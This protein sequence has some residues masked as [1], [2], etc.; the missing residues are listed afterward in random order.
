MLIVT[1]VS[2]LY[3]QNEGGNVR[4]GGAIVQASDRRLKRDIENI[5]YGLNEIVQ[6][7][8]TE[9]YWKGREQEFKS[10]GLIAQEVDEV[11]KNVVNYSE[12]EDEYGVNYMEL[13]PVLIKAI[14]EQQVII[15]T[16]QKRNKV[17]IKI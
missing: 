15:E 5:T 4:I 6:L 12:Y 3:L 16:Q 8:P 17:S 7:R 14:Q 11:I 9:Y 10:L 1:L 2:D 13:I